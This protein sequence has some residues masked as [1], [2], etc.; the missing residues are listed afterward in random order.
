MRSM[1]F[2]LVNSR[3]QVAT[4]DTSFLQRMSAVPAGAS[5]PESIARNL[6][7]GLEPRWVGANSLPGFHQ[8]AELTPHGRD[9]LLSPSDRGDAQA[10]RAFFQSPAVVT[11]VQYPSHFGFGG[12]QS[13]PLATL[14]NLDG[15]KREIDLHWLQSVAVQGPAAET[16]AWE[17]AP[18]A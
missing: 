2:R 3:G 17:R 16:L 14:T 8:T 7:Q 15:Q 18:G 5:L 4:F 12:T 1:A 10:V 13:G 6:M 9:A 11:H